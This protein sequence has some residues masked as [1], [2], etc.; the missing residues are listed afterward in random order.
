MRPYIRPAIFVSCVTALA[1]LGIGLAGVAEAGEFKR[2]PEYAYDAKQ[3]ADVEALKELLRQAQD[4][5]KEQGEAEAAEEAAVEAE[6]AAK[7]AD[8]DAE[9]VKHGG[10]AQAGCMYRDDKLIWERKPG[11]CSP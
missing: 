11:T 7:K 6:V 4:L 2:F 8:A 1:V 10:S 9:A 3:Q 5:R